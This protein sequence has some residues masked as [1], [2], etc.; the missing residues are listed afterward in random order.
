MDFFITW[1]SWFT[2]NIDKVFAQK[3]NKY[4]EKQLFSAFILTLSEMIRF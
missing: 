2:Y 4:A 3:E 1:M